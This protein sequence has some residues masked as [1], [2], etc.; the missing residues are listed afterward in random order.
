[1]AQKFMSVKEYEDWLKAKAVKK[2]PPKKITKK[3]EK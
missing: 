3:E 2:A 1:M